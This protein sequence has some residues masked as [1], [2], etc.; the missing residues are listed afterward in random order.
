MEKDL[1]VFFWG[2]KDGPFTQFFPTKFV[3]NDLTFTSCEQYMMYNK[4][5]YFKDD[6][7]ANKII[8]ESAPIKIKMLGRQVK[9]FNEDE[10]KKVREDIVYKGNYLKFS[11]NPDLKLLL[12]ATKDKILV[13]AAPNDAIW[14]IGFNSENALNN[15]NKWG[16]NLLGKALMKVRND[17][18]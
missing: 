5:K 7:N 9:G 8:K 12:L 6:I 14:G 1:Y 15:K 2:I 4:A 10:W 3:E 17:L 11:Q 13:E 18:K 16:L